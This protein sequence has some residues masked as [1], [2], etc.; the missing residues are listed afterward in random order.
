LASVY[1]LV[2]GLIKLV[3][4]DAIPLSLGDPLL[5]GLE[6]YGPYMFLL[7]A[8][9]G[10]I[11]AFGLF[12]LKNIARRTAIVMLMAGI[13]LLIPRVSDATADIS[14][15]FFIAG[16]MIVV[17]MMMVWYLWQGWT[18]EKFT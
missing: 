2:L 4:P 15:R 9:L 1:L 3:H 11:V 17:R 8:G 18:A 7:T 5:H 6:V 16:S 14:L 13:V 12:R 10:F